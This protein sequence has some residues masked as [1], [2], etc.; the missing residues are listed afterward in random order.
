FE[1]DCSDK[2]M[3]VKPLLAVYCACLQPP[4]VGLL[5]AALDQSN[6]EVMNLLLSDLHSVLY[7]VEGDLRMTILL[8]EPF[9]GLNKWLCTNDN[10]RIGR[11][12]WIDGSVGH[13]KL[14]ALYL[15][16]CGNKSVAV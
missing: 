2:Y 1:H 10:H 7:V 8:R 5:S 16:H 4:S 14:C 15:R 13:N 9:T 6:E 12:F 11:E 3:R